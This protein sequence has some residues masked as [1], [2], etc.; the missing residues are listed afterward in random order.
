MNRPPQKAD[1]W[2]ADHQRN[3]GGT[4][5]KVA[6]PEVSEKG[7]RKA[8]D[9]SQSKL[10]SFVKKPN[11]STSAHADAE[12]VVEMLKCPICQFLVNSNQINEHIDL[13]LIGC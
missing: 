4:F 13:C 3:C 9:V 1:W 8:E 7:K 10:D 2:F 11:Q 6:E 12:E 5:E